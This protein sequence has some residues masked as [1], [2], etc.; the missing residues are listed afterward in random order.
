MLFRRIVVRFDLLST[1]ARLRLLLFAIP[2]LKRDQNNVIPEISHPTLGRTFRSYVISAFYMLISWPNHGDKTFWHT[3]RGRSD[4]P[5]HAWDS[6]TNQVQGLCA[7]SLLNRFNRRLDSNSISWRVH[8]CGRGVLK[9]RV[10]RTE[11][12]GRSH[13]WLGYFREK[14]RISKF[15]NRRNERSSKDREKSPTKDGRSPYELCLFFSTNFAFA[16]SL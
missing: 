6:R 1:R 13:F 7:L 14:I 2:T 8:T 15:E 4:S 3:L 12:N 16:S 10:L 9:K 5:V 11:D